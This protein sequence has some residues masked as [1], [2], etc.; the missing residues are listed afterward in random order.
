[1]S[2]G[3]FVL[4]AA[5]LSLALVLISCASNPPQ[6]QTTATAPV[7][8]S[9]QAAP[10][11]Q[12]QTQAASRGVKRDKEECEVM[13]LEQSAGIRASG[14]FISDDESLGANLA[15]LDARQKLAQSIE[16]MVNGLNRRFDQQHRS[17][18]TLGSVGKGSQIQ[19]GYFEQFLTNTREICRN[20][21]VREDGNYHIYVAVEMGEPTQK[22]MFQQLKKE[23]KVAIDFEEHQFMKELQ[24][25]KEDFRK[26]KESE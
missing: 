14:N 5:G 23:E 17:G 24:V 2:K 8:N 11:S 3:K 25:S 7:Y 21:Y 16:V 1:M 4:L 20:V 15:L 9:V 10:T 13:A 12:A 6:Q 18:Q 19:Q 26:Q 22:A